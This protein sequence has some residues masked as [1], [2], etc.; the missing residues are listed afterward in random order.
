MI[1]NK[2]IV[3]YSKYSK[4]VWYIYVAVNKQVNK[5]YYYLKYYRVSLFNFSIIVHT[6]RL[7]EL[8]KNF[9]RIVAIN[10]TNLFYISK[11]GTNQ[12][13][14]TNSNE[15]KDVF[16]KKKSND[17]LHCV[18]IN[19]S[20]FRQ[21]KSIYRRGF[22]DARCLGCVEIV[23]SIPL[24]HLLGISLFGLSFLQLSVSKQLYAEVYRQGQGG[25]RCAAEGK[26][27]IPE[28]YTYI[29]VEHSSFSRSFVTVGSTVDKEGRRHGL[30]MTGDRSL[31]SN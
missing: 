1:I 5:H 28:R 24:R 22:I 17:L 31:F 25:Q 29:K 4:L 9:P 19:I 18:Y 8:I 14:N 11:F 30:L 3:Q 12:R 23:V 13:N 20:S 10:M 2:L 26:A 6:K 7:L 21:A 16:S 15:D 27:T